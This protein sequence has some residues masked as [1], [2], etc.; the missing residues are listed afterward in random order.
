MAFK[1]APRIRKR[2]LTVKE[3]MLTIKR[4]VLA[5]PARANLGSF[6]WALHG[7]GARAS[8]LAAVRDSGQDNVPACGTV[9]CLAGWGAV[10]LRP[11]GVGAT[12]LDNNADEAMTEAIGR[13]LYDG[14]FSSYKTVG[15]LFESSSSREFG[16]T[17]K[18]FGAPGTKQH[19]QTIANRI[20]Q[21]L[22]R[23]PEVGS[24]KIDVKA[25]QKRLAAR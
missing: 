2:W 7:K 11:D 24:R 10:L 21:Y 16:E 1:Q 6:V 3:L 4:E 19:A 23:Y 22:R 18:T 20:D 25:V 13:D 17:E 9:A 12:R 5:E 15:E 14:V 8:G